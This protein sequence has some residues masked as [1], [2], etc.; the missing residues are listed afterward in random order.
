M[1][2]WKRITIGTA[3]A[4]VAVA[5]IVGFGQASKPAA[6]ECPACPVPS[7]KADAAVAL[8]WTG[9]A[10]VR[11][12]R[13]AE[14]TLTVR[15]VCAHPVQ[16]VAVQVR[17]PQH[18]KMTAPESARESDGVWI[19]DIGTL[20]AGKSVPL[21]MTL[22]HTTRGEGKCQ[23]WVTCTGTAGMK[24]DVKEPK[25]EVELNAPKS[26]AVFDSFKVGFTVR[27][28]GNAPAEFVG[29]ELKRIDELPRF[30]PVVFQT[31]ILTGH[32]KG[33]VKTLAPNASEGASSVV[34]IEASGDAVYEL[35]A[36]DSD[37][38]QVST[39]ATVRVIAPKLNVTVTG[40][41]DLLVNRKATYTVR[42][43][44][45]GEIPVKNVAVATP[46][47]ADW[48]PEAMGTRHFPE[49]APG[50]S[51]TYTFAGI[52]TAAGA[53]TF[54]ADVTGDRN[55]KATGSFTTTVD[56]IA[57]L[58]M[59]TIDT[60]DPV[61]KGQETVYEIRVTNTGTK[62]DSNVV[63]SCPLPGALQLVSATGPVGHTATNLPGLTQVKFEPVRE[64]APNV[65][66]VYLVKV[67]A[68]A[69]G[70]VRFKAELNSRHL[71]TSVVKEEST[72]VYGE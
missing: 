45:V 29:Y 40:P 57:A 38:K 44:N 69:A 20:E 35:T 47:P 31:G 30:H 41:K 42:V 4:G 22:T 7:V 15:N 67:K 32:E 10:D 50:E 55:A 2:A 1:A 59:E 51:T 65:E 62:A 21:K 63:V 11:I 16:A 53:A 23:A 18:A 3:M 6:A 43:D 49:L 26:V 46:V 39:R 70:D 48:R 54:S 61:E 56:G 52:P 13:A 58:R 71:T 25:L 17:P 19:F 66:V 36:T 27:N 64:L 8:E 37:G 14:Y 68:V 28:A 5:A 34:T 9:P 72:R 12:H 24:V 33:T 60:V